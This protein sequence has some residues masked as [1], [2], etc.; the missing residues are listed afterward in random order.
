ML[1]PRWFGY[2]C[3]ISLSCEFLSAQTGAGQ[4]QGTITDASG[5]VVPR[6]AV[7][8]ENVKTE[9]RFQAVTSEVGAYLFPSVVPGE[10]NLVIVAPGMQKWEGKTTLVAGQNAVIHAALQVARSAEQVTVAGDVTPLLTTNSPTVAT[11]V[12]RARIE[13]LPMNGRSIQTLLQVTVPGLEGSSSQPKVYGLRDSAMEILQDGVNLQDRNTGALQS[14]PPGLDTIQEFRVETAVSSAKLE[15]PA[16]AI[17]ITRS[18]TN[19][20]HGSAFLTGRNSGFGVARQRQDTFTKAPHLVRNE[21]GTSVG[22]PIYLPKIYNGKNRSFFFFAWEELRQRQAS[23]TS[24]A[25][26]TGAMRQGDFSGLVDGQN[27]RITLYDPWSVGSAPTYTKTPYTNNQLPIARMSPLAKYM[28]GVTP[29]PTNNLSPLVGNNY[30]G[31]APTVIDNRTFTL[32]AD[33]RLTE[34]DNLYGRFSRGLNNQMNRRAFSTAG[35]PITSDNLYNRETYYEISHTAMASW[36]HTFGPTLFAETVFSTSLINWQYSLNQ[37]SAQQDVSAMFGTPNPFKVNGAPYINNALYQGVSLNGIVPRSQY[38]KV[39]SF[40]QN[41]TWNRGYHQIEFGGRYRQE[42]LD[43]LPDAPSQSTLSYASNATALYNPSTGNTFGTQALTGDNGANFFLGIADSYSQSRPPRNFNM[44]GK[45]ESLYVQDNWRVRRDLTLNLGVRWQYLGPYLDER[46]MTA[47]WDFPSKSLV[48]SVSTK[49]LV[50][51]GYTTQ[52]I[53][54]GYTAIGVK[55]I[56]PEQAKLPKNLVSASKHDFAGRVGFAYNPHF[57]KRNLVI[58]GGYGMYFFPI[59]AR[60]FSELRLNPPMQGNYQ[61]SWNNS[62][63][64]VDGL[65]NSLLRYAPD[66]ITGVNSTN[67]IRIAPPNPGVQMTALAN[68]LPTARAHQWNMTMEHEVFRDTVVRAGMI[69]TAGRNL[70]M[71]E[72]FNRNPVSNYVW[73]VNTGLAIPQGTYANTARRAYDQTTYGDIR[74]YNKFGYSNF[75]G[76]Q[77]EAER[78][79]SK[80]L[81]FQFFYLMSNS[82]STGATPSQG[83]DFTVNAIDQADRFLAGAYPTSREDRIK[84]YRYSRD[85]DVPKHRV[86]FNYL[87]DIPIGRGKKFAGG[88]G[89]GLN[90]LVGGWQI[91]GYGSS[92]S[93]YFALPSGNWGAVGKLDVYGKQF[94]IEDCR[95]GACF[96]GYMYY[97]GYLPATVVANSG[98]SCIASPTACVKGVPAN[99]APV[100]TNINPAV[101]NGTVDANFNNTNNV[102]VRLKDGTNQLVAFDTGLNPLRNQYVNGPWITNITGSVYKSVP[103]TERVTLRINLDAFNML[104][105]PGIGTPNTEGI[106]SLRNSAQ[107]AR[108]LQYTAR[109]TW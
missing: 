97:N 54:D 3:L 87:Y 82:L 102:T 17:M 20:L 46:G 56:T 104:N 16:S 40:E 80:G 95:G 8:L 42:I 60:T 107:G 23:T 25:V 90:R 28:F 49:E 24:T 37:P 59:P 71:M 92:N 39:Y 63:Q 83:G 41:Y 43:T 21:F 105:Q 62:A 27:R 45:D 65:P 100:V 66:V 55:F 36:T 67:A 53:A 34:K 88:I 51:S 26:W 74:V 91:A 29:L 19:N 77:L 18:G 72:L 14:R 61:L 33:H 106:I 30:D 94:P 69:G 98:G 32:R 84:F 9:N 1:K 75:V 73:F 78:R 47:A 44:K 70:D 99:Y 7:T 31:L 108:V 50:D 76:V 35:F 89:T 86:R 48:R 81:A 103:I 12:E 58:R 11:V 79:F 96:K 13:Q 64:T 57:G 4:I 6:A 93:R 85:A 109:L 15:R 38:T 101:A 22:A 2:A 10:Y 52:P 68:D 5:A